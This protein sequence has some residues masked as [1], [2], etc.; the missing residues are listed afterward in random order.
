MQIRVCFRLVE[1]LKSIL[2]TTLLFVVL[3]RESRLDG[4]VCGGAPWM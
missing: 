4:T 3:C 1:A 2:D